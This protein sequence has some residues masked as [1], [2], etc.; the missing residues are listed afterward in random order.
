M[1]INSSKGAGR[2]LPEESYD[3]AAATSR[4]KSCWTS[5]CSTLSKPTDTGTH[6]PS[7]KS[8]AQCC[9]SSA[10]ARCFSPT[11]H[12][13]ELQTVEAQAVQIS[14]NDHASNPTPLHSEEKKATR[15]ISVCADH[16]LV[17]N[18]FPIQMRGRASRAKRHARPVPKDS[19][20]AIKR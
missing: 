6:Q 5:L 7:V 17:T 9:G 16:M 20:N 10:E 13:P 1:D 19:T 14:E 2:F 11:S 4:K 15:S 8:C 18:S 3:T 12:N